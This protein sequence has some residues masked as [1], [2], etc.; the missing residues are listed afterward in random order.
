M[1]ERLKFRIDYFKKSGKWYA[2]KE[3]ELDKADFDTAFN[4]TQFRENIL[5]SNHRDAPGL[6]NDGK[7]FIWVVN[8]VGDH[9]FPRLIPAV[10]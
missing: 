2:G 4:G 5:N 7:E 3:F 6:V 1:S 8:P 10:A 9:S